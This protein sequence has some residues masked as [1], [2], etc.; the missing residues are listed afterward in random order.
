M[1]NTSMKYRQAIEKNR[2]FRIRDDITFPDGS[3]RTLS[4]E[5]V[6]AYSINEAT[7]AGG[8]FEIGAAIVKKYQLTLNNMDGEF[9]YTGFEGADIRAQVGL[10]LEDGTWEDLQKGKYRIVD[11]KEKDITIDIVAYDG[12]LFFDRPYTESGLQY[13]AT[14][15]Q[16][17]LDAC[18]VCQMTF[19]ARSV[20]MGSYVVN[21]R[22]DSDKLT[23]RDIISYCAQIM[24]CFA[25]IN[26][27]GQL[28]FGWYNFA[29]LQK[30]KN[31]I[32]NGGI[33]DEGI[34]YESGDNLHGGSFAP[35]NTGDQADGGS[36]TDMEDYH[37]IYL[38]KSKSIDTDDITITGV[39]ITVKKESG[40]QDEIL[41]Y[42]K[43]GYVLE[44]SDNPLIQEGHEQAVLQH[45][46][47]KVEGNTFR[48]M[49]ITT[50]SDPS[51][52]AG[53]LA[54]VTDRKQK[55][56]FTVI[57]NTTFS[58][59]GTQKVECSAETP[60]EKNY[61]RYGA[62]TKLM[63]MTKDQT[64]RQLSAYEVSMRHF[65]S[66]MAR[67]L[68]LYETYEPQEDGTFIKYQHDKPLMS[69]SKTIWKQTIDAFGVS[70]DG[71]KTWNSGNDAQGNAIYNILSAIGIMAEWIDTRGLVAKD[72]KGNKTFEV[73][74]NTGQVRIIADSFSL[75]SGKTIGDI[76]EEKASSEVNNFISSV[77]DPKIASL[78]SQIDGQIETW[79]YDYQPALSNAPAS[80][81]K[82]EEDRAKHEGDLFYWKSKGYSYRFFKDGSVW[83]WQLITDSDITKA[84]SDASKAQDTADS[85]RRVFVATPVPPYDAGDLWTQG[86]TG[87]IMT[88]ITSRASGNY[89]STDWE[90]RNK[91]IDQK[92][93]D[94]AAKDAV[95]GQT[96]AD[97]FDKI[98]KNGTVQG[99]FLDKNGNIY[100][101][102][103]IA[104]GGELTLGGAN[105][106]NGTFKILD[107]EGK[108]I[109]YWSKDGFIVNNKYFAVT[110]TGRLYSNAPTFG[111]VLYM[112]T[113]MNE[114]SSVSVE[115]LEK[116]KFLAF[117]AIQSY[118]GGSKG[119]HT[120]FYIGNYYGSNNDYLPM[121]SL[122]VRSRNFNEESFEVEFWAITKI[123]GE[124]RLPNLVR[125][126]STKMAVFNG[127]SNTLAYNSESSE[128]YKNIGSPL[129]EKDIEDLYGIVPIW[130]K[131]KEGYL[132]ESDERYGIEFPMFIAEDVE[133]YAPLAVDHNKNGQAENWNYRVMIPYMFQMLKS[134]KETID[135]SLKRIEQLE[136]A[137]RKGA[138]RH[139]DQNAAR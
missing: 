31:G 57:T 50:Q 26:N 126:T 93:A 24:G 23:F 53:D 109:G 64:S 79:Y 125:S 90:K 45:V 95:D 123:Y 130:A 48:P 69:E 27:L 71:G 5:D 86:D 44:L 25:F 18:T 14:I 60:T 15:N 94:T 72:N 22:P 74:A 88:C 76:A 107:A 84:L 33:F 11:A 122:I 80:D 85:K 81:W 92:A 55:S 9:D 35:W 116:R 8:K 132:P 105:N 83:K 131:Y 119:W 78:Q 66:L 41:L 10:R 106:T 1:I 3:K 113:N 42:G 38:L 19:N 96:Q 13:P 29:A 61:T 127:A 139:G 135:D 12:M 30:V 128:R 99:L 102:F 7:S 70:T 65:S 58:L 118:D 46:G 28:E 73:D 2:E 20:E 97:I 75:S 100:F 37:H 47:Q 67:S 16:I 138:L 98:T 129:T 121:G 124:L 77:Y 114:N 54:V 39:S 21:K 117:E 104:K 115:T 82:T 89:V 56:C 6:T 137:L 110:E 134:Q 112:S 136:E 51:I 34:P 133:K 103:S 101:S 111:T 87:D 32:Y 4:T 40:D 91:Y 52:M 59:S 49:K 63:S 36:F 108:Q 68:G 120:S 43:E 62:V 17:I